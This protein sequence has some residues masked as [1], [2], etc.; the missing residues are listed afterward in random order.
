M[1]V[2]HPPSSSLSFIPLIRFCSVL[3][4]V[5]II[6]LY[7]VYVRGASVYLVFE[8]MN[9]DLHDIIHS[10]VKSLPEA[11]I[12]SIAI[13][14]LRG[15]DYCHKNGIVHRDMKPANLLLNKR[16]DLK[17]ADFGLARTLPPESLGP[18]GSAGLDRS[19]PP[20]SHQV[21]TRWYRAPELLFGA[22]RYGTAVD[23]WA[24]GCILAELLT[25]SPLFPGDNDI[26]QLARVLSTLGTPNE[27]NW[28]GLTVL[29]DYNKITFPECDPIPWRKLLPNVS[30]LALDLV[31][32][33][34]VYDPA[35][36]LT[37]SD[38]LLHPFFFSDPM[39][40]DPAQVMEDVFRQ[41]DSTRIEAEAIIEEELDE[42]DQDAQ[43]V[44]AAS[45]SPPAVTARSDRSFANEI[46]KEKIYKALHEPMAKLPF[47]DS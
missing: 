34:L 17:I 22:R 30:S 4:I 40:S 41:S 19:G 29:P 12:K 11:H 32:K 9:T 38:A 26:D 2:F 47:F 31:Q 13:M 8:L 7:D 3:F 33:V 1:S 5:Q 42:E 43:G 16:G 6:S 14:A 28:P 21:A 36:R 27:E 18:V 39:P 23:M 15:L 37:A 20:L 10:C 45:S 24:F 44:A 35:K 46:S 25:L